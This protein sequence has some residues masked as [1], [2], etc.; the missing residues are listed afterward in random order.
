MSILTNIDD[1]TASFPVNIPIPVD[2][3]PS[4]SSNTAS[5]TYT[6]VSSIE[7]ASGRERKVLRASQPVQVVSHPSVFRQEAL[8]NATGRGELGIV[9]RGRDRVLLDIY[10]GNRQAWGVEG[11][12][13]RIHACVKNMTAFEVGQA[14]LFSSDP[15]V[16]SKRD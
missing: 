16:V 11:E 5:I 12:T 3:P 4:F 10:N 8:V 14:V 13:L 7:L 15:S 6:L 9:G 2:L 1:R